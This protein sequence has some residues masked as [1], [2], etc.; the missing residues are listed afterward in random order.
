MT[1][2]INCT[3]INRVLNF[4]LNYFFIL[5]KFNSNCC[6]QNNSRHIMIESARVYLDTEIKVLDIIGKA[7]RLI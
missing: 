4:L 7:K 6:V 3:G 5:F 2:R 1:N